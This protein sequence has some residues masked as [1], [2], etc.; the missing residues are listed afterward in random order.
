[1]CVRVCARAR[2][3]VS[4]CGCGL[5]GY[6]SGDNHEPVFN[7]LK[8]VGLAGTDQPP[9][10][11]RLRLTSRASC[12]RAQQWANSRAKFKGLQ[13]RLPGWE[14]VTISKRSVPVVVEKNLNVPRDPACSV[15]LGAPFPVFLNSWKVSFVS[16]SSFYVAGSLLPGQ[17]SRYVADCHGN[18]SDVLF[19]R[20]IRRISPK[21]H[22][23]VLLYKCF[24][25][26]VDMRA[27]YA[28]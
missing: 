9:R 2:V 23:G 3:R 11:S 27:R 1:M 15:E 14:G 12:E 5:V 25:L 20:Y 10:R 4:A 8:T 26:A 18:C 17:R 6:L 24:V 13:A 21:S 22:E 28:P 16:G 19:L 7:Q